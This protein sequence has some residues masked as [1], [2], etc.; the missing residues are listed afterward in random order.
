MS[1]E[2]SIFYISDE[3]RKS[4]D[5][6]LGLSKEYEKDSRPEKIDAGVGVY[7]DENGKT[8][9]PLAIQNVYN[10]LDL[11]LGDY[12]SPSG[13]EEYLGDPKFI[14]GT[15]RL[16]FGTATDKML[17]EKKLPAIRNPRAT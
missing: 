4:P 9:T 3:L 8:F 1:L 7:R 13:E 15:A 2:K 6:I 14:T 10:N 16:I 5:P 12:L 11:G 17:E